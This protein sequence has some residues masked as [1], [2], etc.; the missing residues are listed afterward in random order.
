[1]SCILTTT[2]LDLQ[3]YERR[4]TALVLESPLISRTSHDEDLV[5]YYDDNYYDDDVIDEVHLYSRSSKRRVQ[6]GDFNRPANAYLVD[7]KC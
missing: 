1:M 4:L 3:V 2:E 5:E 6:F 7:V